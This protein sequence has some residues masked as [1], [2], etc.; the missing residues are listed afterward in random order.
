[1]FQRAC[2]ETFDCMG[3]CKSRQSKINEFTGNQCTD[4]CTR[5]WCMDCCF[6]DIIDNC[7]EKKLNTTN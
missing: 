2:T 4:K 7:G 6:K 5:K 1:M 3:G